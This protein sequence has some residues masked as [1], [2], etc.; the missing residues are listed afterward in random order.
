M[1]TISFISFAVIALAALILVGFKSLKVSSL[2]KFLTFVGVGTYFS[3]AYGGNSYLLIAL[4]GIV[5]INYLISSLPQFNW[6]GTPYIAI[7]SSSFLFW[8]LGYNGILELNG[9]SFALT[10]KF[11]VL[12]SLIAAISPMLV[13][14]KSFALSK[15]F[16]LNTN[17][18]ESALTLFFVATSIYFTVFGVG[19]LGI[20]ITM[21]FY[22]LSSFYY[23]SLESKFPLLLG[24]L[25][26]SSIDPQGLNMMQGDT[27]L[28]LIA[29]VFALL[30]T[31]K[32]TT[33]TI[34][35]NVIYLITVVFLGIIFSG[36]YFAGNMHPSMGGADALIY[37]I[38]GISIASIF[39]SSD[40]LAIGLA[41]FVFIIATGLSKI[42]S[43]DS[44]ALPVMED[45]KS[46]ITNNSN[47][48][49]IHYTS[50]DGLFGAY[51]IDSD[52][53]KID[54]F[55][56]QKN[57]TK[58][59][60]KRVE[61]KVVFRDKIEES[62]FEIQLS[63][64]DFTTFNKYRDESLMGEEYFKADKYS[65]M[66][67]QSSKIEKMDSLSYQITGVFNMLGKKNEEVVSLKRIANDDGVYL[68]GEGLIDRTKYG[69]TP[70]ITEGNKVT[71]SYKIRLNQK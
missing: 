5:S 55:L 57:E 3:L 4:I 16:K 42:T 64:A 69:M 48:I 36:L 59:L 47:D 53:S 51:Q 15:L 6:K 39:L 21:S 44:S 19:V 62:S 8:W 54:F 7:L 27:L 23:S 26:V 49:A 38:I 12:G 40:E 24:L 61:G 68:V 52:S 41:M 28:G 66:Q 11:S 17:N 18:V 58:G 43:T 14:M 56:G 20:Y 65:K 22:L 2:L 63:L 31:D 33:N 29:G 45:E 13:K 35:P 25:L 10:N 70:S 71:F 37:G 9:D 1:E 50:L 60:F 46:S 67:F 34:K 32:I 30:F